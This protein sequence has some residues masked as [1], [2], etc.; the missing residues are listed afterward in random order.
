MFL[1]LSTSALFLEKLLFINYMLVPQVKEVS[2]LVM[3][4]SYFSLSAQR[5]ISFSPLIRNLCWKSCLDKKSEEI[6]VDS[7]E[8]ELQLIF[9]FLFIWNLFQ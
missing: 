7:K 1:N 6:M 5:L 2:N 3:S 9:Q 8:I 4:F